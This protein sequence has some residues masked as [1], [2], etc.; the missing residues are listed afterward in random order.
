MPISNITAQQPK[1]PMVRIT[2]KYSCTDRHKFPQTNLVGA[3][4]DGASSPLMSRLF[5]RRNVLSLAGVDA[6]AAAGAASRAG[7]LPAPSGACCSLRLDGGE[8]ALPP[9]VDAECAAPPETGG[10]VVRAVRAAACGGG[11]G[12]WVAWAPP[13]PSGLCAA[14]ETM[15][16]RRS[17]ESGPRNQGGRERGGERSWRNPKARRR[18][19]AE[20]GRKR[21]GRGQN[22]G[23]DGNRRESGRARDLEFSFLNFFLLPCAV[24]FAFLHL[25]EP[26]HFW[27]LRMDPDE[28]AV[29]SRNA[30]A[31]APWQAAGFR[32]CRPRTRPPTAD[33]PGPHINT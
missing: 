7:P 27:R 29:A 20:G 23:R 25:L 4:D 18:Q 1:H 32:R 12:R 21:R 17:R 2:G 30:T 5:K 11:G 31:P 14:P 22:G 19:Q 16:A 3:C 10:G 8:P 15:A 24:C 26:Q 33:W 13:P 9:L 6:A 28:T